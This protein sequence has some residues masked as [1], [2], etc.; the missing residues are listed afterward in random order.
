MAMPDLAVM[1]DASCDLPPSLIDSL[2]ILCVPNTVQIGASTLSDDRNPEQAIA[3]F[4]RE[5][6]TGK[7][8]ADVLPPSVQAY[9][10]AVKEH[11]VLR[12]DELLILTPLSELSKLHEQAH[13][14]TVS[15]ATASLEQRMAVGRKTI[16]KVD[17]Q[18]SRSLF[19]AHGIVGWEA[20]VAIRAGKSMAEVVDYT[21]RVASHATGYYVVDNLRY[22]FSRA[23]DN[24]DKPNAFMFALGN[25][26]DVKPI[27]RRRGNDS[28]PVAK[29]RGYDAAR[30][31]AL[32]RVERLI[33]ERQLLVPRVLLAY[34]GDPAALEE[35]AEFRALRSAATEHKV[36]LAVAPMSMSGG[37][38]M[39]RKALTIGLVAKAHDF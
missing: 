12:C 14:A 13:A 26:L 17:I 23:R 34:A 1:I 8:P 30:A 24:R 9:H 22:I 20:A 21:K 11:A 5:F 29:V 4:Q 39:G 10:D 36:Q 7:E 18:D 35:V 31:R 19:A 2:N 6:D 25:V 37:L 16:F 3:F 27:I 28:Q 38:F 15:I 32:A 33:T